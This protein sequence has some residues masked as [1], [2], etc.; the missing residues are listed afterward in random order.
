MNN[1][2]TLMNII[3][4]VIFFVIASLLLKIVFALIGGTFYIVFRFGIPLL[5][6]IGIVRW[7]TNRSNNRRYN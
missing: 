2:S 4:L 1:Q 5:I 6:A 3:K 7:L